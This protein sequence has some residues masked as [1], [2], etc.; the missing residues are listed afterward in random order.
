MPTATAPLAQRPLPQIPVIDPR[1]GAMT[2]EFAE[3]LK[4]LD[5]L[6]RALRL[7]IP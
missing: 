2:K 7:E 1:T 4:A 5:E 6:V 3:Y